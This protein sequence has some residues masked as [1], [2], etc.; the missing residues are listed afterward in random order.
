MTAGRHHPPVH[1]FLHASPKHV[2]IAPSACA[3]DGSAASAP[4]QVFVSVCIGAQVDI[5]PFPSFVQKQSQ[6]DWSSALGSFIKHLVPHATKS[7]AACLP[8]D[9]QWPSAP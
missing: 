7:H 5:A 4:K 2:S 8:P 9:V 1:E 6:V 3:A